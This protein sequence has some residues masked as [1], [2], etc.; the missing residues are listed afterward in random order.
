MTAPKHTPAPWQSFDFTVRAADYKTIIADVCVSQPLTG[1]PPPAEYE[2]NARLIAA[3]PMLLAVLKMVLCRLDYGGTG[4]PW[5]DVA[6]DVLPVPL[7]EI[8]AAIDAA[9]GREEC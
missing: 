7:F 5:F 9:E 2:H 1:A 8:R 6:A 4:K 3:A